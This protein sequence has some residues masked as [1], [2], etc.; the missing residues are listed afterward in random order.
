MARQWGWSWKESM[1]RK[2]LEKRGGRD[3]WYD[4]EVYRFTS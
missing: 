1:E 4:M 3:W 2:G